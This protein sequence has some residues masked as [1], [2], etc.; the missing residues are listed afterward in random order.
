MQLT[1]NILLICSLLLL[2]ALSFSV[3]YYTTK[4]FQLTLAV[5][6]VLG[7]YLTYL[8]SIQLHLHLVLS[9]LLTIV[10]T[11]LLG[12]ILELIIFRE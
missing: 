6:I 11:S 3:Y 7:A 12:L 4:F 9:I 8:F 1:L 10:V 5:F 2:V